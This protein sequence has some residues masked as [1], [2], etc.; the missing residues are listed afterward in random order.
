VM[1]RYDS[2]AVRSTLEQAAAAVASVL[3]PARRGRGMVDTREHGRRPA[4]QTCPGDVVQLQQQPVTACAIGSSTM[5]DAV[6]TNAAAHPRSSDHTPRARTHGGAGG[7]Q[8]GSG[9]A[10]GPLPL[11]SYGRVSDN[12]GGGPR[13]DS[14]AAMASGA[15]DLEGQGGGVHFTPVKGLHHFDQEQAGGPCP[16]PA[17]SAAAVGQ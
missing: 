13:K 9:A 3:P 11:G 17:V 8:S 4:L 14:A 7:K 1:Q 6:S 12:G 2:S 5:A 16:A 10:L 15:G